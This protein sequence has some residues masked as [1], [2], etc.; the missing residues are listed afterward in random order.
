MRS[1]KKDV[2]AKNN[3]SGKKLLE[4]VSLLRPREKTLIEKIDFKKAEES[5]IEIVEDIVP[6]NG[7]KT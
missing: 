3:L 4:V 6:E 7:K 2:V 1:E 5:L